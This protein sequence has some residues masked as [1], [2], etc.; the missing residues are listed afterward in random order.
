MLEDFTQYLMHLFNIYHHAKTG[1]TIGSLLQWFPFEGLDL[2]HQPADG[3]IL[4]QEYTTKAGYNKDSS[5]WSRKLA[6]NISNSLC[7]NAQQATITIDEPLWQWLYRVWKKTGY[8]DRKSTRLN[9]S[10]T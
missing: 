5:F 7:P 6:A 9:S 3:S 8:I 10:H 1:I 4:V 2:S